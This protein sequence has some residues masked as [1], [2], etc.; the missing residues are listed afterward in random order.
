VKLRFE[1]DQ[2][3]A[4]RR[5][6]DCP[7]RLVTVDVDPAN[8]TQALR[9][10]I[11]ARMVGTTVHCAYVRADVQTHT[12]LIGPTDNRLLASLPTWEGFL[13]ALR[14]D[15]ARLAPQIADIQTGFA[16]LERA[17]VNLT[18]SVTKG[19]GH[20]ALQTFLNK[21]EQKPDPERN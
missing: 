8:L 12:I 9:E 10:A 4:F 18:K 21:P 2:A 1:V 5:G 14:E 11:A 15:E 7:K 16:R 19:A 20:R 3:E 13:E 17:G 6:V